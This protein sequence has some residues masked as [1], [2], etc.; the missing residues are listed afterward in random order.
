MNWRYCD[1]KI[2]KNAQLLFLGYN[3]QTSV[4]NFCKWQWLL[5][6]HIFLT[7]LLNVI[8]GDANGVG[9]G[10]GNGNDDGQW[11]PMEWDRAAEELTWERLLG[12][13]GSL[14]FLEH[15]FWVVSLN[16]LFILVF[17]EIA[18]YNSTSLLLVGV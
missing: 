3:E 8:L 5:G 15:V 18:F 7:R 1:Q 17:G 9:G 4:T 2:Q 12:L 6:F 10:D 16:T 13:D 14:V 11:N